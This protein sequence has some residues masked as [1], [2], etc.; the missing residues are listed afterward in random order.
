MKA[1][2][3][4]KLKTIVRHDAGDTFAHAL[5]EAAGRPINDVVWLANHGNDQAMRVMHE[6]FNETIQTV[7]AERWPGTHL[8]NLEPTALAELHRE[9]RRRLS[10]M[11]MSHTWRWN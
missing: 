9:V 5:A 4:D 2:P 8:R 6:I 11:P 7:I 1:R 10:A 3:D